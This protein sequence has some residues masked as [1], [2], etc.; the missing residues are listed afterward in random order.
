MPGSYCTASLLAYIVN[1]KFGKA[2]P[3]Y[4]LESEFKSKIIPLTRA[5]M[6]NWFRYA[7]ENFLAH[8]YNI[9]KEELLKLNVINPDETGTLVLHK[10]G[11]KAP[12][13]SQ[14]WVYVGETQDGKSISLFLCAPTRNVDNAMAFLRVYSGPC[15]Q[16]VRYNTTS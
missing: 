4:R 11:R 13:D 2:V 10:P 9:M 16:R 6:G 3:L 12:T 5:T 1:E 8:I 14:M 7:A 15:L